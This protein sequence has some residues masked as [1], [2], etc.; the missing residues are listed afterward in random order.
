M[1]ESFIPSEMSNSSSHGDTLTF[2]TQMKDNE[3]E[4]LNNKEIV[5]ETVIFSGPYIYI[6]TFC[7]T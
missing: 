6:S 2:M 4:I 1:K 5:H 7:I 3:T